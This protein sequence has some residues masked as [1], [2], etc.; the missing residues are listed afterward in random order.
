MEGRG[1][2]KNK[3]FKNIVLALLLFLVLTCIGQSAS[4]IPS[5]IINEYL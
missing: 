1:K 4:M 5:E 2:M 3:A